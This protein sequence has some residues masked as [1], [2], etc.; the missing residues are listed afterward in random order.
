MSAKPT[1]EQRAAAIAAKAKTQPTIDERRLGATLDRSIRRTW[2]AIRKPDGTTVIDVAFNP[3]VTI[4][5]AQQRY[6]GSGVTA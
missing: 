5:E 4:A 3:E 1:L 6:P 2:Y